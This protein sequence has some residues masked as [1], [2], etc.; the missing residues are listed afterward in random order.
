[1]R[2]LLIRPTVCM[3]VMGPTPDKQSCCMGV[4]SV[5]HDPRMT[6][7]YSVHTQ[8]SNYLLVLGFAPTPLIH[9]TMVPRC[10]ALAAFLLLL[11]ATL[12]NAERTSSHD[13]TD[14]IYE[15]LAAVMGARSGYSGSSGP[16]GT[17]PPPNPP[18]MG[19]PA[20][21][22]VSSIEFGT[23]SEPARRR[24]VKYTGF[25][26]DFFTGTVGEVIDACMACMHAWACCAISQSRAC[27]PGR[28]G[29]AWVERFIGHAAWVISL[30]QPFMHPSI[31]VLPMCC[32]MRMSSC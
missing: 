6:D 8:L 16:S 13:A 17:T 3:S 18:P 32:P 25:V 14:M 26:F 2:L 19:S 11:G 10:I 22:T 31:L 12:S 1:M 28:G 20:L 27:G 29:A 23:E 7:R 24:N 5:G 4:G 21:G 30:L 9:L 15:R